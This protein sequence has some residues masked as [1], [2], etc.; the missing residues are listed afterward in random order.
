[1][2]VSGTKSGGVLK[3][4]GAKNAGRSSKTSQGKADQVDAVTSS[5]A[6]LGPDAVEVSDHLQTIEIIRGLVQS[7]PDIRMSEVDRISK[8][9][10]DGTYKIDYEKV[11]DAFIREVIMNEIARK[12][13]KN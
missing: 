4:G 7:S 5:L 13:R 9:L 6:S 1:M 11:A 10:K 3:A 2:K 8:K 12:P